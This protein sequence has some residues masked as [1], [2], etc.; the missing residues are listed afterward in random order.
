M[1]KYMVV[2]NRYD[3]K[4]KEK[5]GEPYH[6]F[7]VGSIVKVTENTKGSPS[8]CELFIGTRYHGWYTGKR[9]QYIDGAFDGIRPKQRIS[10]SDLRPLTSKEK[11]KLIAELI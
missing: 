2:T 5:K 7:S 6:S 10:W 3:T 1:P 11:A 8:I 9:P 4:E